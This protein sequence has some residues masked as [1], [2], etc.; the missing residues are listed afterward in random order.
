MCRLCSW[1]CQRPALESGCA[2]LGAL[3]CCMYLKKLLGGR[4]QFPFMLA[5]NVSAMSR[6]GYHPANYFRQ[7]FGGRRR[8]A[9][10]AELFSVA[11]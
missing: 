10:G 11:C 9:Q 7:T 4:E 6:A 3:R 8:A 5:L 2:N 1:S